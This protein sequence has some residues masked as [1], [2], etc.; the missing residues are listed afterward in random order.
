MAEQY[1]SDRCDSSVEP[2]KLEV[3]E[4]PQY[5]NI[6]IDGDVAA[7]YHK[8]TGAVIRTPDAHRYNRLGHELHRQLMW[9]E[10][11]KRGWK[12]GRIHFVCVGSFTQVD[13]DRKRIAA[14]VRET[15][16]LVF[17]ARHTQEQRRLVMETIEALGWKV[18]KVKDIT[19]P[20][21]STPKSPIIIVES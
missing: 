10:L 1:P 20:K 14:F 13:V 15:G 19:E 12:T 16:F 5:A 17:K 4:K 6:E 18:V 21:P 8:A 11:A 9:E 3:F 2:W 7:I